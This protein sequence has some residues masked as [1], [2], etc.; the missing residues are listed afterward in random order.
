MHKMDAR[1]LSPNGKKALK[2]VKEFLQKEGLDIG[3]GFFADPKEWEARGEEYSRQSVLVLA[4]DGA[5]D[6][7][8][9]CSLDGEDYKLNARFHD[10]LN[11][12]GFMYEEGTHWYGGVYLR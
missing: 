1:T 4:Y 6:L 2:V 12:A 10:A 9:A 11:A 7:R 5:T 3:E 8:R